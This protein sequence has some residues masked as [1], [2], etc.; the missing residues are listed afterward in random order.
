[1][2]K[3]FYPDNFEQLLKESADNFRMYPSKRVWHSIYNDLHPSRRWPSMAIWLLL[4]SSIV[5]IGLSNKS[6]IDTSGPKNK[7]TATVTNNNANTGKSPEATSSGQS[8][9]SIAAQTL[10][11]RSLPSGV[12]ENTT[13][14]DIVNTENPEPGPANISI[15]RQQVKPVSYHTAKKPGDKGSLRMSIAAAG[16]NNDGDVNDTEQSTGI[17]SV[18]DN[19]VKQQTIADN[20]DPVSITGNNDKTK[21]T[22]ISIAVKKDDS[23]KDDAEKKP[24]VTDNKN[25]DK[26]WIEDFAF[27]NKPFGPKFRSHITYQLYFT[28]SVG[29]RILSK[30]SDFNIVAPSILAT[31]T[32]NTRSYKTA[33]SQAAAVNM[34]VGG[35]ILYGV[36]KNWKIKA[37]VQLNYTNYAINAYELKHPTVTTL[38]L[39]DLNTGLPVLEPRSTTLANASGVSSK[40]LSNS[41]YQV[42]IPLG[43]DLKLAGKSNLKW[44]AGATIQPS[45]IIGGNAYLISSDLKNYVEDKS[46]LR[47]WNFNAAVETFISYKTK[48]GITI[49]AGPQFR[50]QLLSTYSKEYNY[51]EKLYNIGLKIGII[52]RF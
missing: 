33:L 11:S 19:T 9:N 36:S 1:M 23:K 2:E 24:T 22:D 30:N 20:T 7:S 48:G 16:I 44:Y 29:Y 52:T 51:S 50:Y 8:S 41:T 12:I 47:K 26:E 27:H 46:M 13:N 32:N 28:P 49:N 4:I 10:V 38:T 34:E 43:A 6:H 40:K 3:N 14:N 21:S 35:A 25:S 17:V 15:N 45:Y 31:P 39:N 18:T 5:Y 42:S 37:G